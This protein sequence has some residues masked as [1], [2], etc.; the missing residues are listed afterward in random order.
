MRLLAGPA[1]RH[2]SAAG[3]QDRVG[4]PEPFR[5]GVDQGV[6][7]DRARG[8]G[9]HSQWLTAGRPH[10]F[11]ELGGIHLGPVPQDSRALREAGRDDDD[12]P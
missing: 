2:I 12:R 6:V 5:N 8:V 11:N 3:Q 9:M 4:H 1:G 10:T 7:E